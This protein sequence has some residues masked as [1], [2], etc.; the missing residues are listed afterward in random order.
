MLTALLVCLA[1]GDANG[2]GTERVYLNTTLE[3]TPKAQA[4]YYREQSGKD[5]DRFIGKTFSIDGKLKAQGSYMDPDLRIE[6]GTFTFY[7]P[8]G[9]V[10]SMGAY[11]QGWKSG[12]WQRFDQWGRSLSEKIYDPEVLANVVFSQ[13]DQMPH[14]PGGN[15]TLQSLVKERVAKKSST[16]PRGKLRTTFVVEKDGTL[17]DVKVIQGVGGSIDELALAAIKETKWSPGLAKGRPV[18]VQMT[19]PLQF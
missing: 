9:K 6:D 16:R 14:F 5:G 7:H 15:A 10:E 4:A 8:N 11:A 2:Q 17:S 12:M 3:E 19:L 18:R 13:P 1:M